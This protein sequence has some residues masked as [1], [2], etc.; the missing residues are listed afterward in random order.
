MLLGRF[1]R[2]FA[3]VSIA[4]AF[5]LP[6]DGRILFPSC[7]FK[8]MFHLPC[9]GCGLSRSLISITRLDLG[10]AAAYNP[11]G[12]VVFPLLCAV[13]AVSLAPRRWRQTVAAWLDARATRVRQ[14]YFGGVAAFLLF[15][16]GRLVLSGLANGW[17]AHG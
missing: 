12:L 7:Y 17:P 11:F 4:V 3:A 13:L 1:T 9:P 16:A 5:V 2:V 10:A 14:L 6:A 8:A 15:G